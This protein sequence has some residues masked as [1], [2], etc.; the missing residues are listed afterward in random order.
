MLVVHSIF[1]SDDWLDTE[2][3]AILCQR[4]PAVHTA[5]GTEGY[6]LLLLKA[7][8]DENRAIQAVSEI[9]RHGAMNATGVSIVVA[10][11]LTLDDAMA[12]QFALSCCDCVSAFVADE[13]VC[14]SNAEYLH[15]LSDAVMQSPEFEP[16]TVRLISI[17]PNEMGRR[18]AWQF[19]GVA[20][21]IARPCEIQVHW[22]KARL[23]MHWARACNVHLEVDAH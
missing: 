12:G 3:R 11:Q 2:T 7:G 6:S 1:S 17:P 18:F 19:L 15:E 14:S 22:K 10:Q 13:V 20:V 4:P 8:A 23:M 21:G 5:I 9:Q 16:V